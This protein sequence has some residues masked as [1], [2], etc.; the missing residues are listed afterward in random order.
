MQIAFPTASEITIN[1]F[2]QPLNETTQKYKIKIVYDICAFLAH[3]GH[4]SGDL[5]RMT[6]NLNY[7]V[8]GLLK[9][10][11]KYFK[12]REEAQKYARQP[13]RIASK[14]YANRMGNSDEI[15]GDGWKYRGR[16]LIQLTGKSNYQKFA[17]H[18]KMDL[19]DVILFLETPK[20]AC[21]SAGYFWMTNNCNG[22]TIVESTKIIN[23]GTHGLEDRKQRH[24]RLLR[25]F[26]TTI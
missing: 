3:I 20:G 14:A 9:V 23:G 18:M 11:S 22:K 1:K 5:K 4:E 19:E 2:I 16:G 21:I 13:I 15:S 7:S 17:K 12:T 25:N 26:A 8:D 24:D 10:F 6:E